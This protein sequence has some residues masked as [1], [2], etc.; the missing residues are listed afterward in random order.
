VGDQIALQGDEEGAIENMQGDH[1]QRS[2]WFFDHLG[3]FSHYWLVWPGAKSKL[4]SFSLV[5]EAS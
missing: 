5:Q 2:L 1:Q 4:A 3:Q